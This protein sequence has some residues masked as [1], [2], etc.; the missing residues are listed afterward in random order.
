MHILASADSVA[1][2]RILTAVWFVVQRLYKSSFE[3][4]RGNFKYTCDT[5]FFQAVKNASVLINDV[6]LVPLSLV[7]HQKLI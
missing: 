3:K 6:S 4:N 1:R 5:P 7:S 2:G